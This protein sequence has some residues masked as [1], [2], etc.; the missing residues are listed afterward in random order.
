MSKFQYL[1]SYELLIALTVTFKGNIKKH[2]SFLNK[3]AVSLDTFFVSNDFV[4]I[5]NQFKTT[6]QKNDKND[7][8]FVDFHDL[9]LSFSNLN[10][11][12]LKERLIIYTCISSWFKKE[13]YL[14]FEKSF[15]QKVFLIDDDLVLAIDRFFS[16]IEKEEFFGKNELFLLKPEEYSKDSLDGQWI[17][18]N[19][20]NELKTNRSLSIKGIDHTL[21]VLYIEQIKIFLLTCNNCTSLFEKNELSNL[22]AWEALNPGEK[23]VLKK[24]EI[25]YHDLKNLF[26]SKKSS[27]ILQIK[28]SNLAYYYANGKGIKKF[29]LDIESGTLLG[30][31]GKEGSG[32]S[33]FLKLMAGEISSSSGKIIINAYNLAKDLYQLKGMIGFVPEEDLLYNELT[34]YENLYLTAKLY[35]G[36]ASSKD[37]KQKVENLLQELGLFELKNSIV[38]SEKDKYLQPGQR[39]L[40]NIALELLRD[41]QILI[42]DNAINPL[43][44]TDSS[45]I[46]EALANYTFKGNI[47]ITS[48]TQTS[49]N[50]F[51]EFDK[52]FILDDGGFPVYY[53]N[54]TDTLSYF[55]NLFKQKTDTNEHLTADTILQFISLKKYRP[56]TTDLIRYKTPSELY[57]VF[58]KSEESF[59]ERNIVRKILPEKL[60]Y[61][62]ALE[63]QYIIFFI[64]D[65]K[66]KISRKRELL[67]S[68]LI[69]PV[70]ALIISL[71]LRESS[72]ENYS[73][74]LNPYI[75]S[76]LFLSAIIA[77]FLGLIQSANEIFKERNINKKQEYLNLSRFSYINSKI[78]YLLIISLIQSF[79][80]VGIGSFILIIKASFWIDWL[81]FFSCQ[82]F[83]ILLG[84]IFS[85]TQKSLESIYVKSIPVALVIQ[86]LLGGGFFNLDTINLKNKSYTPLV[87]DLVVT[88]WAYEA[89][90]VYHFKQNK[91]EREFYDLNRDISSGRINSLYLL[92]IIKS[93]I[94]YCENHS[95]ASKDSITIML[96]SIKST[97]NNLSENYDIFSYENIKK[98]NVLEFNSLLA[99]DMLEY[100]EYLELYFYSLHFNSIDMKEEYKKQISDSLG[101]EYLQNLKANYHNYAIAEEATNGKIQ[102]PIQYYNGIP[103]SVKYP[104]YKYPD[105]DLG[106]GQMYIPEKQFSGQRIDTIEFN[107]SIIW[108]I[109]LMLYIMLVTNILGKLG[110]SNRLK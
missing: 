23:I 28:V 92:P 4:K 14:L 46:I 54:T 58:N 100:L 34:V 104:I 80:F 81:I 25:D 18:T 55:S 76:Y 40:L 69:T 7:V 47:V 87:A 66:T 110:M 36:K 30:V 74:S 9:P 10:I 20:P 73:Y 52:I 59:K 2:F 15:L 103:I 67:Y 26:L 44:L 13:N 71:F 3:I 70:L 88:R 64:R 19:E 78:T 65:F 109:N 82:S 56:N 94:L 53:G 39:R 106:R 90:M 93:Q 72:G 16:N 105:S 37:I 22:Y 97:L 5:L 84:L 101:A 83:G 45:K 79:L 61:P 11:L 91:Y 31:P 29:S 12:N 8:L 96:K 42:V 1:Q 48:I 6:D 102:D 75:P 35:L 68:I 50:S 86:I 32:K 21:K 89:S 51:S 49:K 38:G 108:M 85:N 107:L 43:S 60:L 24:T 17:K 95:S 41:P 99:K 33:T 63:R 98:L 62:P 77:V 57:D 27:Q